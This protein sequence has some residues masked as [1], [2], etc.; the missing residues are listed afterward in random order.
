MADMLY[1]WPDKENT[2]LV[3]VRAPIAI[4]KFFDKGYT[5]S[6]VISRYHSSVVARYRQSWHRPW[7]EISLD[8]ISYSLFERRW[9]VDRK[10]LGHRIRK[11]LG[12]PY[13]KGIYC[14]PES[15]IALA[16]AFV[17]A[18]AWSLAEYR[19]HTHGG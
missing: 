19:P 10:A 6:F 11:E 17:A 7:V 2:M 5:N 18:R 8:A 13:G 1:D 16:A 4:G 9:P 15:H 14:P 3:M 12:I